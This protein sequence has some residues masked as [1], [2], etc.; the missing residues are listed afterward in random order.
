MQF[1]NN[2]SI[3]HRNL[4]SFADYH[5]LFMLIRMNCCMNC[6]CHS[7]DY[8]HPEAWSKILAMIPPLGCE[9]C[10]KITNKS[11]PCNGTVIILD[12]DRTVIIITVPIYF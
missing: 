12:C 4:Y 11:P 5:A 10:A 8:I 1:D 7:S 9:L 3:L 6:N 2:T